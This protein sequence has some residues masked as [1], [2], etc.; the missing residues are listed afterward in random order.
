MWRQDVLSFVTTLIKSEA[1]F[2]KKY[3]S[4]LGVHETP[5]SII[6]L[7]GGKREDANWS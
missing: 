3:D 6:K 1:T 4:K 2:E 5:G 7:G